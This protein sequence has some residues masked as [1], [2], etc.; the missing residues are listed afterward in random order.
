MNEHLKLHQNKGTSCVVLLSMPINYISVRSRCRAIV[1]SAPIGHN[2]RP[3]PLAS[4]E[5]RHSSVASLDHSLLN[6]SVSLTSRPLFWDLTALYE[7]FARSFPEVSY[8]IETSFLSRE[9]DIPQPSLIRQAKTRLSLSLD[10][11]RKSKSTALFSYG[12]FCAK[13]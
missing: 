12:I 8:I 6:R 1:S 10:I 7:S 13:E 4:F 3:L 9:Y 2:G 5:F 11:A